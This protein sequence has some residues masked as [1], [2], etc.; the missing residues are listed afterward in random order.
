MPVFDSKNVQFASDTAIRSSAEDLLGRKDFAASLADAIAQSSSDHTIVVALNGDWGTGKS[1]IK[2]MVVEHLTKRDIAKVIEFNPWNFSGEKELAEGF[3]HDLGLALGIHEPG[4]AE[5]KR[6]ATWNTLA[7]RLSGGASAVKNIGRVLGT[8]GVP[9]AEVIGST[10]SDALKQSSELSTE[11]KEALKEQ[12]KL[13]KKTLSE[14]R[15]DLLKNLPA[16]RK[17]LLVVVDDI[18]R[19]TSDEVCLLFRMVKANAD[20]PAVIFL[21]LFDRPQVVRALDKIAT[22]QGE[23][24]LEK[25]VQVSFDVPDLS[26]YEVLEFANK[27][28]NKLLKGMRIKFPAAEQ[29]RWDTLQADLST[30]F[31]TLRSVRRFMN[32]L[33][34]HLSLFQTRGGFELNV[35]DLAVLEVLRVFENALYRRLPRCRSMLLAEAPYFPGIDY[36]KDQAR[37]QFKQLVERVAPE[38]QEAIATTLRRIFPHMASGDGID[39][40]PITIISRRIAHPEMFEAYFRLALSE[41]A[42][43]LS[44]VA[45]IC[46]AT[47]NYRKL[48]PVIEKYM[49]QGRFDVLLE[50]LSERAHDLAPNAAVITQ[51]LF[52]V[53]DL[54]SRLPGSWVKDSEGY[55]VTNF[56]QEL[57]RTNRDSEDRADLIIKAI[58]HAKAL[59]LPLLI[60]SG[61]TKYRAEKTPDALLIP[62]GQLPKVQRALGRRISALADRALLSRSHF[63]RWKLSMWEAAAGIDKPSR[64]LRSQLANTQKLITILSAFRDDSRTPDETDRLRID[65]ISRYI[66]VGMLEQITKRAASKASKEQHRALLNKCLAELRAA[67]LQAPALPDQPQ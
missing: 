29:R 24:F 56:V 16:L 64:W 32:S 52:D 30:Y 57:V 18:D 21:L 34:F 62:E 13:E 55:K 46:R 37:E 54:P 47:S 12:S 41:K 59:H 20:F 19:L 48:K 26:S 49:R 3:F 43:P 9:M 17:P 53:S 63:L 39:P 35:V 50:H 1:S 66:D 2:N 58:D 36:Q 10:L 65:L 27:E 7:T 40:D 45:R 44:E 33:R 14:L 23:A 5:A 31:T 15:A 38:R 28:I 51:V 61:E 8:F 11:A 22:D 60:V 42:I 25:I 4:T 6:V 67:G